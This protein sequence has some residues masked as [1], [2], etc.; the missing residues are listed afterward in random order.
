[1]PRKAILLLH[2]LLLLAYLVY[3]RPGKPP[4]ILSG[5]YQ[6]AEHFFNSSNP[7]D[8]TDSMALAGF[9]QVIKL[10]EAAPNPH[11]DTLLFQSY[12]KKGILLD[13]KNKNAEARDAYLKAAAIPSR[14]GIMSDSLLFRPYVYAG[15]D[16][17][18]LNNFDSANYF[19]IRAEKL[20]KR[21]PLMPET[22]RLYNTLGALHYVN[23]NY[24]QSK[25]YFN[26]ALEFIKNRQPY[27]RIFA[28]GLQSNIASSFY[29]QGLYADA[30]NIYSQI[31]K[32][33][34]PSGYVYNGIYMNMGKAYAA[35]KKHKESLACFKKINPAETPGVLNELALAH[36]AL[37]Q[38]D[39]A[40]YYLDQLQALK[41]T[42]N[43]NILD[44]GINDLY[45]AGMLV[46]QKQYMPALVNLQNAI[47]IFAGN[48][49]NPDIYANPNT[50]TGSYTYYRLF[51]AL[52]KK[53]QTFELLY[54]AA[55]NEH[56]LTASLDAYK[57]ALTL[58]GFI[59][60]SYD[61][62]D[63][64]IFLKKKSQDV[65]SEALLVCLRLYQL[66]PN[67]AYLE[68]AFFI[69]E[70]NKASVMAANLRQRNITQ[71]TDIDQSFLQTERNIKFAIARLDV[72]SEQSRNNEE[73]KKWANEK[74]KYEIELSRLQK[75][76]EQNNH[77]FQLKYGEDYQSAAS[78]RAHLNNNQALF[79]FYTT[80]NAL[81]VF[82]FTKSSF[83]YIKIDSVAELQ[84]ETEGWINLLRNGED[85]RKFNG[86]ALGR[87]LYTHLIK[88]MQSLTTGKD[89]WIIIPDGNLYLLPFESLPD[90]NTGKNMLETTTISYQFS[91]RFMANI[92]GNNKKENKQAGVL[93]FAPFAIKG[94]DYHQPGFDFINQ[95]P[96]SA[97]EVAALN[98]ASFINE[99]ATKSVF[100]QQAGNYPIIHLATHAIADV[101]NPA[102]SF[103]AFYPDKKSPAENCLYLE[104]IYGL[105][106]D[107]CKLVVISACETG[108]GELVNNEGIISLGRAFAYAGCGATVNSLWKADD[109]ATAAILKKF[110][111][112]LEQGYTKSKALQKAK[113]D[114]IN[115]DALYKSPAYWSNLIL[116]GSIEPVYNSHTSYTWIIIT[117]VVCL[118]ITG[119]V[120]LR[121][122][123]KSRR[124]SQLPHISSIIAKS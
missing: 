71:L 75:N 28:L 94:A 96:A 63:A 1:M 43:I 69:S 112:Y 101:Q 44:I 7:T 29:K 92:Q 106:L 119:M 93:S 102:A 9:E 41:K 6:K 34:I 50:F 21:F 72:K 116:T 36:Y 87:R 38:A 88:P 121:K 11:Y 54:Q 110:H 3:S 68:E 81:H 40:R 91:S 45:R 53:A 10:L 66:H 35:I 12:L 82:A 24:L 46:D 42:G 108:K 109:K 52:Y 117:A 16:Y 107:A 39:S 74:G 27:D 47:N 49:N 15:S 80:K 37:Q 77:Y 89:E 115:S 86:E 97:G 76:M 25:N 20:I 123:K 55:P 57:A 8:A 111:E 31:I 61:T 124:F 118:F 67:T 79:N 114:Y 95:L 78:L 2:T 120:T 85:G 13:V 103:I 84:Q 23:G 33:K 73:I 113:L 105:N 58:L 70:K 14:N 26:Q 18:S 122:I 32:E 64:K 104:E 98:G 48:F 90:G 83:R 56:Y 22:E 4:G 60:K 30:L 51:D 59:E 62:D 5:T 100:L 19:L 99:Q 65:Y 17:F